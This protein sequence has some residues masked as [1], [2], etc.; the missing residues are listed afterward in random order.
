MLTVTDA[1]QVCSGYSRYGG[2][3]SPRDRYRW[4]AY[5]YCS[6]ASA[7]SADCTNWPQAP[8]GAE[9][10]LAWRGQAYGGQFWVGHWKMMGDAPG[11]SA[12]DG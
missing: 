4:Q 5:G 10:E 3:A 6:G 9:F 2:A 7:G 11:A 12:R 8:A 1:D